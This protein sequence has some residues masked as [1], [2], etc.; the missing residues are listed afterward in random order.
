MKTLTAK[1]RIG[2]SLGNEPVRV[3][4]LMRRYRNLPMSLAGACLVVM[5]EDGIGEGVF[6]LDRHLKIFRQSRRRIVP[7]LMPDSSA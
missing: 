2:F 6:T 1:I 3:F 5:I 7:V 4:E